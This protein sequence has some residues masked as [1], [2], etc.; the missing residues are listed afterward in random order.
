MKHPQSATHREE[1][2][3]FPVRQQNLRPLDRLAGSVRDRAIETNLAK[4]SA[5]IDNS[6]LPPCCHDSTPRH[7][8]EAGV[9]AMMD[10]VI[11]RE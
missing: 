8:S 3:V 4:S 11:P 5:P 9:Q 10:R 7:E 6:C 2:W 1:R